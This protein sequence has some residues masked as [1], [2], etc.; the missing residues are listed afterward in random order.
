MPVAY[1]DLPSG[2]GADTKKKLVK[3][4]ADSIHHA[5][6]LPDTRVLLREWPA[7]QMSV[8]GQL[9]SPM[10]P[11]CDFV[12]HQGFLLRR[13]GSSLSGSAPRLPRHAT[14]RERRFHSQAA[15]KSARDGYSP[16]SVSIRLS[17]LPST[18]SWRL[19]IRWFSKAWRWPCKCRR[20]ITVNASRR[21][22]GAAALITHGRAL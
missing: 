16:S 13:N 17:G 10:R 7:E 14:Y 9:G 1:L 8:D 6:I 11:I 12:V 4:V 22:A 15:R 20:V 19:R 21:W 18:T 2:L 5:Y 3:E